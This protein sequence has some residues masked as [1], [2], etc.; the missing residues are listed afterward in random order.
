MQ[1]QICNN[2]VENTVEGFLKNI[3]IKGENSGNYNFSYPIMN[4]FHHSCYIYSIFC[5]CFGKCPK[6]CSIE[7]G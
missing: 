2:P 6:F 7:K 4:K 3:V 1:Y 5:K